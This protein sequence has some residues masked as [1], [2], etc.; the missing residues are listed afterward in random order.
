MRRIL[1]IHIKK[2]IFTLL[3]LMLFTGITEAEM[4][5]NNPILL[6]KRHNI[7]AH[8]GQDPV[9]RSIQNNKIGLF[10]ST[11][12]SSFA[13]TVF[14]EQFT[15]NHLYD[16]SDTYDWSADVVST[17]P[18]NTSNREQLTSFETNLVS[19]VSSSTLPSPPAMLLFIAGIAT[20]TRRRK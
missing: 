4:V 7:T 15:S 6:P 17:F 10:D 18:S 11:L 20:S 3:V 2:T 8:T 1:M 16:F 5:R 12:N 13:K 9:Y 19:N 14:R